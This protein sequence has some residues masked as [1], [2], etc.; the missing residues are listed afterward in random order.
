MKIVCRTLILIIAV[1]IAAAPAAFGQTAGAESGNQA[2][3]TLK[4]PAGLAYD[5]SDNLYV[6]DTGNNRILIFT[7]KLTLAASFGE[8]GSGD[9]QFK[10]PV[11]VAVDSKGRIIVA[12]AGNARI[13]IFDAKGAFLMAFGSPG[14]DDGQFNGPSNVTADERD[15]II[16][17]DRGNFRLQV[18]DRDGKH[19]FTLANRTGQKSPERIELEV[20]PRA[21]AE[22]EARGHPGQSRV[23]EHRSRPVQ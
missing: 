8:E 20:G 10:G 21:R 1:L 23:A 9:G 22:Q 4:N 14:K 7:P 5:H 3:L 19:L 12:D 18:F 17:T 2:A 16:V 11:D 6:A 13:E 15:N